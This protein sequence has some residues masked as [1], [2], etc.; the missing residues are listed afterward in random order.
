M[1]RLLH[2]TEMLRGSAGEDISIL[3][4]P[5]VIEGC[6]PVL[7]VHCEI[8]GLWV[9]VVVHAAGLTGISVSVV[10]AVSR[11]IRRG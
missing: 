3:H 8:S 1:G 2:R 11:S 9:M 7:K 6:I 5:R 10:Q 4:E